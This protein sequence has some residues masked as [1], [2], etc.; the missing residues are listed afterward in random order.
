MKWLNNK[1][2]IKQLPLPIRVWAGYLKY[3]PSRKSGGTWGGSAIF[4][5]LS[6]FIR[7]KSFL[8]DVFV[9]LQ[10][11]ASESRIVIN[12]TDFE[13]FNHTIDLWLYKSNEHN[14]LLKFMKGGGVFID[15]GA[16]YG[17]YSLYA[18]S[19]GGGDSKVFSFEPQSDPAFAL[20]QSALKNE[21]SNI[22]II[23]SAVSDSVGVVDFYS[24]K[25]GS[26]VG[27]VHRQHASQRSSVNHRFVKS[28]SLDYFFSK[29][30]LN[31]VDIIKVDVEG[32]EKN[33]FVGAKKILETFK[34]YVWFEVNPSAM[35]V[36]GYTQNELF[37][38]LRS[39]GYDEFYDI[40][41]LV[42]GMSESDSRVGENISQLANVIAVPSVRKL[43][44]LSVFSF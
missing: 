19:V 8:K 25:S 27:S 32:N 18:S 20:T 41:K 2:V 11:P 43:D 16:N 15:I 35:K 22:Q 13:C 34:P 28:V 5:I 33:V 14:I 40:D 21:L 37:L 6:T 4:N 39:C 36:A 30:E 26:G 7:G 17:V 23:Q 29:N 44:F 31:R 38:S 3:G 42:A 1:E 24:P 12:I 9:T 10:N